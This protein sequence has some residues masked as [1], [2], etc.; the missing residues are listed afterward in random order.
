MALIPFLP[1]GAAQEYIWHVIIQ[2]FLWSFVGNAWSLMG[3][4]GLVSLGHGAFLGVGA[5]A[6]VLLWNFYGMTPVGRRRPRRPA[7]RRAGPRGRLPVLAL[8]GGGPLLRARHARGGRG[9][10]PV[11]RG[12]AR[13]DRRLPRGEPQDRRHRLGP[14][15]APVRRQARLLLC[16]H[17]GLA[18]RPLGVV[19]GGPQHGPLGHGGDRRG[20]DRGGLGGHPGHALQDGHH[21]AVGRR[22]PRW[23][24]PC[25]RS[26]SPTRTRTRS[27]A[28]GSR[29]ASSSRWCWAGCTRCSGP[30]WA[31]R[32]PSR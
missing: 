30:S 25:S 19:A 15:D 20:R 10:A 29:C 32:S 5:Y 13:L 23:A 7:D 18:L 4:F 6:T 9:G 26:T 2:I 8:P 3:R 31:P 11:D 1:L 27:P 14:V 17:G 21:R 16:R 28:S 12:R 24:A 22:S